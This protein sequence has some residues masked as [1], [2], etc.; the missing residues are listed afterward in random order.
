MIR[1]SRLVA[2]AL[3]SFF[4]VACGGAPAPEAKTPAAAPA[5][6]APPAPP[7]ADVSAVPEPEGLVAFARL[8]KPNEALKVVGSWVHLPM[9]GAE[10]LGSLVTGVSTG[11]AIDLDFPLDYAVSVVGTKKRG[12]ISA[13]VRSMDE[14]KAAFAKFKLVPAENGALLIQGLEEAADPDGD[15]DGDA[16]VC[17]LAPAAGAASA[18]LIC[19]D[20][21]E[22]LA[23]LGPWLARTAPR[24]TYP[25]DLHVEARMA[26]VRPQIEAARRLLPL[27]A[28]SALGVKRG[29]NP[30]FDE[31]FHATIEDLADFAGDAD[32]INV[33]AMLAEAQATVTLTTAFRG[34]SSTLARLAVGHPER[35][36]APPPAFWKL[37]ADTDAAYFHR[38]IDPADFDKVRD[39]LA[40]AIGAWLEKE[41]VA[42]AD[43]KVLRDAATHTFE[44]LG[45]PGVYGKGLDVAEAT[46][47]QAAIGSAKDDAARE[48]AER[49]AAE[50]LAGW[51]A[52]EIE[53][54]APKVAA[55][56]K[57][58]ATAWAR[59]GIAK[60]AKGL[61]TDAP[62]PSFK[63]APLPKGIAAK[64]ASHF[65]ITTYRPH[66]VE[67]G[68]KKPPQGKP[69]VLHLLTVPEGNATWLVFA[70]DEALAVA[71]ANEVTAKSSAS[72]LAARAGLAPMKDARMSAGGFVSARGLASGLPFTWVLGPYWESVGDDDLARLANAPEQGATAIPFQ[73]VARPGGGAEPAGTFVATVTVP[74]EAIE[75][76]VRL[77]VR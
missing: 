52:M 1:S 76:I 6:K 68:K 9:P 41:K 27:F 35:A 32:T 43:R 73:L 26:P 58:W 24:A 23:S 55:T 7:P 53:A 75:A 62:P 39:H 65:T 64:D 14:A 4:V 18:R 16:R 10:Q 13:A 25:A 30:A 61:A 22:A 77:A 67:K 5:P 36:D 45:V 71:K 47:A 33:D 28:G 49:L 21:D 74:K 31:L 37:P 56:A 2:P 17:E 15:G 50:K 20:S 54:P 42:D 44:M 11:T 40:N 19:G 29:E 38:Q 57:E 59:P 63:T 66:H 12:A 69:L 46:R 8:A 70:A 72:P 48:E 60:W 34:T 3:L 51:M